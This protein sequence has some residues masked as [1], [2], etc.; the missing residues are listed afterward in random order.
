MK[1]HYF[2]YWP[3]IEFPYP[4]ANAEIVVNVVSKKKKNHLA[5]NYDS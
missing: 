4:F 1:K 2:R 3:H 5:A